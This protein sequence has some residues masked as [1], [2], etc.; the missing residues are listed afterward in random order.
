MKEPNAR[1]SR[2]EQRRNTEARIL[3][4]ACRLFAE[5]GYEKTTI[6]AVAAAAGVDAGLV[7]HY[8]G[9]KE[10]LFVR[11]TRSTPAEP[12]SGTPEQVTEQLLAK[13]ATSLID[14]PVESL[15]VLRSMLTHPN[16][17]QAARAA[18]SSHQKQLSEAIPADDAEVRAALVSATLIG[19]VL[20]RHLLH[21]EALRE[22]DPKQIT[23]LLRPVLFSLTNADTGQQ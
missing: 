10:T 20:S 23:D 22:A 6:R 8:F 7:M 5:S 1:A 9:S 18:A 15:A 17:T 21:F 3:A 19:V 11:A 16:A 2:T 13:L 12:V 14:E 4:A